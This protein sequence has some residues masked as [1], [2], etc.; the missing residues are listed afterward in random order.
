[1]TN[2]LTQR[3]K[4]AEI[5]TE[6]N[7]GG[8]GWENFNS[9]GVIKLEGQ[10]C[11]LGVCV[12]GIFMKA[13]VSIFLL[14]LLSGCACR[15]TSSRSFDPI[16]DLMTRQL[17][18]AHLDKGSPPAPAPNIEYKRGRAFLGF[19]A[20]CNVEIARGGE[21]LTNERYN[22]WRTNFF[23]Q[24]LTST[25]GKP[26]LPKIGAR[27]VVSGWDISEIVFTT[28]DKRFDVRISEVDPGLVSVVEIA[29]DL[30]DRYDERFPAKKR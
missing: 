8:E 24:A 25:I 12:G 16:V 28:T 18:D 6:G 15:P 4:G 23:I 11:I 27:A 19:G 9:S 14:I 2:I 26:V 30:A 22:N 29:K 7:E 20:H 3:R 1:M 10:D 13:V 21:I 17:V 5:F